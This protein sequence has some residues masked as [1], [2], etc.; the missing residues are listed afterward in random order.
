M[1]RSFSPRFSGDLVHE[2]SQNQVS[3][4]PFP[5]A[6]DVFVHEMSMAEAYNPDME[7]SKEYRK[8]LKADAGADAGAQVHFMVKITI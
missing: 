4:D 7:K 2:S 5:P 8:W 6:E 3:M 1:K